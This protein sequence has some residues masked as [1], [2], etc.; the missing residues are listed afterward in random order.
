M[1]IKIKCFL[2]FHVWKLHYLSNEFGYAQG[3][4]CKH[5]GVWHKNTRKSEWKG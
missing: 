3:D 5:C 4:R 1:I 2:G